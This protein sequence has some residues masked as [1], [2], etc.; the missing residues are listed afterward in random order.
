MGI[1]FL[2][3]KPKLL[4]VARKQKDMKSFIGK[5]K[6]CKLSKYSIKLTFSYIIILSHFQIKLQSVWWNLFR[7]EKRIYAAH[8]AQQQHMHIYPVQ[9]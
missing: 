1:V 6:E 7:P 3:E 2:L 9:C 5:P 8:E 4:G